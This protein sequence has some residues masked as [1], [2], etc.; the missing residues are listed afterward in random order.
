M[1][2]KKTEDRFHMIPMKPMTPFRPPSVI[3]ILPLIVEHETGRMTIYLVHSWEGRDLSYA[4]NVGQP[5]WCMQMG[6]GGQMGCPHCASGGER[7]VE[8]KHLEGGREVSVCSSACAVGS[9]WV[10]GLHDGWPP[11]AQNLDSPG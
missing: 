2:E 8:P 6:E 3:S 7:A 1:I 11:T 9:P 4:Y 10:C 5:E